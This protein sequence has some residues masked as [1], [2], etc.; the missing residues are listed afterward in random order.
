MNFHGV[1]GVMIDSCH[2]LPQYNTN[3]PDNVP[4]DEVIA[5]WADGC[6]DFLG[7]VKRADPSKLVLTLNY[8]SLAG[9]TAPNHEVYDLDWFNKRMAK[10]DGL[11]WEDP[12][13]QQLYSVTETQIS[14]DRLAAR[15]ADAKA[16]NKFLG[17]IVNTNIGN[18]SS[19]G[20]TNLQQQQAYASY[21]FAGYLSVMDGPKNL[22]LYYTPIPGVDQ[23]NSAAWFRDFDADVGLPTG[24]DR[25]L[26][27]PCIAVSSS[28]VGPS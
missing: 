10:A 14:M 2:D 18:Q 24:P 16:Q 12:M 26:R 7:E 17:V 20:N 3:I 21:Y 22:M 9:L 25:R 8:W 4:P 13:G 15:I 6:A 5:N 27:R 19:F 1:D 28:V 23:F 11:L